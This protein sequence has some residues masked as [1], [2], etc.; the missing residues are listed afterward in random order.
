MSFGKSSRQGLT[1]VFA[2]ASARA[3][4]GLPLVEM[5][6]GVEENSLSRKIFTKAARPL[7][8]LGR[9]MVWPREGLC[10][11]EGNQRLRVGPAVQMRG[12]RGEGSRMGGAFAGLIDE[13]WLVDEGII[14]HVV[15]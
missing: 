8:V 3:W 6:G 7:G 4:V 11:V 5:V 9:V 15:G 10:P 14:V 1:E 12:D 2:R 13:G